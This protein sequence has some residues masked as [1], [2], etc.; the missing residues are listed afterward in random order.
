MA[1]IEPA[2]A[3]PFFQEFTDIADLFEVDV[4]IGKIINLRSLISRSL[5]ERPI[6]KEPIS[7]YDSLIN[8]SRIG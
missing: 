5:G 8:L 3:K 4:K 7:M 1:G 2:S 6:G